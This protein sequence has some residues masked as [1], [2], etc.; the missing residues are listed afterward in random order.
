LGQAP[1]LGTESIYREK[2]R[3]C[4]LLLVFMTAVS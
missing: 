3:L 4:S 2:F 1:A